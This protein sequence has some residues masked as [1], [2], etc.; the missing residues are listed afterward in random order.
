MKKPLYQILLADDDEIDRLFFKDAINELKIECN[1]IMVNDGVELMN[2]LTSDGV[3]LPHLI[4]L[5]IN[6]PKK[7]GMKALQEI[8]NN[9]KL[10]GLS[11]VMYSTSN[12]NRDIEEA[13][14]NGAN[15]YIIK[16][17]DFEILKKIISK[18][19]SINWQNEGE[20]LNK[21]KFVLSV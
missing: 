3:E 9:R 1:L 10:K 6:M 14:L 21:K 18:A 19:I 11:V 13:I 15:G 17:G 5:D 7:N 20:G 4:F 16:P 12:A 8:R 2:F